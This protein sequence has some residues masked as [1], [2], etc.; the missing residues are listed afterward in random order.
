MSNGGTMLPWNANAPLQIGYRR[1]ACFERRAQRPVAED[2][3]D[4]LRHRSK[5]IEREEGILHGNEARREDDAR[6]IRRRLR[7][8]V[9]DVGRRPVR[10]VLSRRRA[11]ANARRVLS[12]AR[13]PDRRDRWPTRRRM[14]WTATTRT[15]AKPPKCPVNVKP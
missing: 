6:R 1:D 2:V 3:H 14:R 15:G 10:G 9:P 13:R 11:R 7:D 4:D 12:P 5:D 8:G